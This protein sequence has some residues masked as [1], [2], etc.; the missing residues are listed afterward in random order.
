MTELPRQTYVDGEDAEAEQKIAELFAIAR[1]GRQIKI[2]A[3]DPVKLKPSVDRAF[4]RADRISAFFEVKRCGVWTFADAPFWTVSAR[5][6]GE[7]CELERIVRVPCLFVVQFGCGTIV[8][9]NPIRDPHMT[10]LNWG[11]HDRDDPLD[12]ETGARFEIRRFKPC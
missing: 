12:Y 4:I 5:K 3:D 11:R 2:G 1:R 10:V 6:T 9:L 7:L 8:W